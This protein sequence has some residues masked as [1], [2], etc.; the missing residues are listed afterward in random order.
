[1]RFALLPFY[2]LIVRSLANDFIEGMSIASEGVE[3]RASFERPVP[4]RSISVARLGA[5]SPQQGCAGH[6]RDECHGDHGAR[7]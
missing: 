5:E 6:H 2:R 4:A 1:V 7:E 3:E